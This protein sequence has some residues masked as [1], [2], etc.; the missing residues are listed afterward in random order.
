VEW[1]CRHAQPLVSD[2]C[3]CVKSHGPSPGVL[4]IVCVDVSRV[5]IR[6]IDAEAGENVNDHA[7]NVAP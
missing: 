5:A 1:S 4:R 7:R 2:D 3:A 6:V